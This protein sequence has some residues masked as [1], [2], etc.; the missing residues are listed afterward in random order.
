MSVLTEVDVE[1]RRDLLALERAEI[2]KHLGS[3]LCLNHNRPII[4]REEKKESDADYGKKRRAENM[5]DERQRVAEWRTRNPEKYA[6]QVRRYNQRKRQR[7][8]KDQ[9][10]VV[11]SV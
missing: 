5:E 2:L 9:K 10:N 1:S 8:A 7:L 4:T 6:E 11:E 3:P